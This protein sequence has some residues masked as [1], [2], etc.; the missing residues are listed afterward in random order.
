MSTAE[1]T[2]ELPGAN[3][4]VSRMPG[5]WLLARLG[6]R[7][8]RPG[9][10]ELTRAML[11]RL[12]VSSG[13][14]VVELAPG[15]GTTLRLVLAMNPASYT[16]V[17]RDEVAVRATRRFLRQGRDECRQGVASKTGLDGDSADVI[18]GE[19]ML[20]MNT[21]EQKASII[22]EA[23]RVLKDGGRYGIHELGLLP[24]DLPEAD[25][26]EIQEALSRSIHIGARPLT[27]SE[28]RQALE[29]GGFEVISTQTAPM[30]LLQLGRLLQ[31]EGVLGVLRIT[32]NVLRS[33]AAR[34]RV[35]EMRSV[36]RK[37][38]SKMC[39]VIVVARKRAA[40]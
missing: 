28:W 20:T 3:L 32:S 21:A 36:F 14:R 38:E 27:V 40:S 39:G 4:D 17:E 12:A 25:K 1:S 24:D 23:F 7:V 5:H 2:V 16:G 35:L 29:A 9:G 10:L 13:D 15:L 37:Y 19:A 11:S 26:A 30:H 31:D 8:L 33:P 22:G 18:F 34:R 6:K